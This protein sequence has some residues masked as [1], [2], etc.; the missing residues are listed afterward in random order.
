MKQ[1]PK[2]SDAN[3]VQEYG[4]RNFLR[5]SA[6]S[7]GVTVQEFIKHRDAPTE[8]KTEAPAPIRTDWLRPPG[9]VDEHLFLERCTK[10]GECID[11]CPHDSIRVHEHD[12]TPVLFADQTPCFLCDDF[13]CIESCGTEALLPINETHA[14]H[15]GLAVVSS[16]LCTA[17]QGCHACVSKCPTHALDLD[18]SSFT[19]HVNSQQCVG[20]GIC[21]HLCQT[22]TFPRAIRVM[23]SRAMIKS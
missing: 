8:S 15:M 23:P 1:S 9:A 2:K 4:R 17:D 14:V 12:Q 5:H 22:V 21:E 18:F 3:D 10:C 11:A 16:R 7:I 13:P 19:L 6:V 20:C